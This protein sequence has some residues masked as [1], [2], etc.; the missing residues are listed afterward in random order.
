MNFEY[1]LD[2]V[3]KEVIGWDVSKGKPTEKPG[4]FGIPVAFVEP[5]KNKEERG[6]MFILLYG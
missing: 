2:A 4:L 3:I 1:A 5:L 6:F